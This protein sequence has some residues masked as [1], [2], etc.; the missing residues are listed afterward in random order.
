MVG[1]YFREQGAVASAELA[2][3]PELSEGGV[4]GSE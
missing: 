2:G 1:S 3:G 4:S